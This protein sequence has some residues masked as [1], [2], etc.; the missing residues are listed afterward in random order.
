MILAAAIVAAGP[1]VEHYITTGGVVLV[2]LV[3]SGFAY[4]GVRQEAA[5]R[6]SRR[7]STR[8]GLAVEQTLPTGNGFA[9][10]VT[11]ALTRLEVGLEHVS[12]AQVQLAERL[13]AHIDRR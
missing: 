6:I 12:S 13:D 3:T 4:L 1:E 8:A 10:R 11:D 5:I 7:A 2:A 9:N